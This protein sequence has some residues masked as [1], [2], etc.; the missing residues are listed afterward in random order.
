M[1]KLIVRKFVVTVLLPIPSQHSSPPRTAGT[2]IF[3]QI[4]YNST[5]GLQTPHTA[6]LLPTPP[7]PF[8][9]DPNLHARSP[10]QQEVACPMNDAGSIV[11]PRPE[12][13]V[14]THILQVLNDKIEQFAITFSK[15]YGSSYLNHELGSSTLAKFPQTVPGHSL[16]ADLV[17]L[18][19][20]RNA[21]G[22]NIVV[23]C[24]RCLLNDHLLQIIFGTSPEGNK[25]GDV[26]S[27]NGECHLITCCA[28]CLL[29]IIAGLY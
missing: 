8:V 24:L 20:S 17:S 9:L 29:I 28:M 23:P 5:G 2:A 26:T 18:G 3:Y 21:T 16:F 12:I 15:S 27:D 6:S 25:V 11:P 19:I 14:V 7:L 4:T 1:I 13:V 22:D 10:Q